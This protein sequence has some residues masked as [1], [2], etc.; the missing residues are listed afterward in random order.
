MT[1]DAAATLTYCE[2]LWERTIVPTLQEYIRIPNKSP[3]F[4][5][6]WVEAGHM[7]AATQLIAGWCRDHLLPGMTLEIVRLQGRTPLIFM[8]APAVGGAEGTVL[9]YGHLDKQPE[10]VGWDEAAGLGP[11]TPVIRDGRLYGRGGADDGYAAFASLG[12]LRALAEQDVPRARCVILIEAG[13]ESGS[14]D[15]PAYMDHLADRIGTPDLVVCLDSGCGSYDRMWMTTSLRGMVVGDLR[16]DVL[17]EGV[18]SG[19]AGGVVPETFRVLRSLLD[20]IEDAGTG[21]LT[22]DALNVEIPADRRAQAAVAGA[23]LGDATWQK[24][25]FVDG[26]QAM[27][28]DPAELVLNR[29][30]R[31]SL[32]VTGIDGMPAI[33]DAGN[34]LRPFTAAKLSMRLPPTADPVAAEAAVRAALTADPPNGLKVSFD[35]EIAQGW[36]APALSPW[37][38]RAVGEAS[39]RHFGL[40]AAAMGEGGSIPFMAML[41]DRYPQAQFL[42][43]GVLGPGSNAHGPNEF[44]DIATGK[45]LTACVADVLAAQAR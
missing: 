28:S 24:F 27:A 25:P 18:H 17:R 36:N 4:D 39:S 33:V 38:E 35:S 22:L 3:A 16:V 34:V 43:T 23:A 32:A 2:G 15:L 7:E 19:D 5:P 37:L 42:I 29:T 1:P 41:G 45:R 12:A 14:P 11:W 30:W 20:R 13:E 9:L 40:D 6:N 26:A 10:M 8:E 44:L 31:P 21:A